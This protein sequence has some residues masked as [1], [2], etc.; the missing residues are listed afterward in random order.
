MGAIRSSARYALLFLFALAGMALLAFSSL[1][2]H[3]SG[4]GSLSLAQESADAPSCAAEADASPRSPT[5]FLG[6]GGFF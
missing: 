6:C 3:V 1:L 5:P 4:Q 2:Q